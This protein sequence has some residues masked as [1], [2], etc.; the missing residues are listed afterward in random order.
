[1]A[2]VLASGETVLGNAACEPHVQD[3]CRFL[4][5]LGAQHRGHRVERPAHHGRRA[6]T[7]AATGDRARPHRGRQLHRPR[8]DHGRRRHDRRRRA[9]RPVSI[10]PA[11]AR[12]GVRIELGEDERPRADAPGAARVQDDLGGMIPKIEDGPWPAF[13]ADLTSIARHRRDA[14]VRHGAR[15][16]RRCSR[17]VCSSPTS[18]CRWARGSSSATRTAPSSP[19]RRSSYGQRMESPDIR[20][21]HGDAACG[22]LRRRHVDDRR[23][24]TRS[25]RATSASTSAYARSARRSSASTR[26]DYGREREARTENASGADVAVADA[27]PR[28]AQ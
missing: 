4:V 14:G 5:S 12:L 16:S 19:A 23:R 2:A 15:S 28:R 18:S 24:R 17:T 26:S 7:A 13:P 6:P 3:L 27:A 10:L 25:T 22:A 21:G 11:F 1:M 9:A 20:A 8:R